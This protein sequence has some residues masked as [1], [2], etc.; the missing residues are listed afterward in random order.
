MGIVVL[1]FQAGEVPAPGPR[2][3]TTYVRKASVLMRSEPTQPEYVGKEQANPASRL[4]SPSAV[5]SSQDPNAT[6]SAVEAEPSV[7]G[8]RRPGRACAGDRRQAFSHEKIL[9]PAAQ[10]VGANGQITVVVVYQSFAPNQVTSRIGHHARE[11]HVRA[12]AQSDRA[13]PT[14]MVEQRHVDRR[15]VCPSAVGASIHDQCV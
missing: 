12:P 14:G 13:V 7:P 4:T 10:R 2:R 3:N 9:L 8:T 6:L 15:W 11:Q 5:A 1:A